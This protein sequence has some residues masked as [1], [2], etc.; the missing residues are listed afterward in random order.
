MRLHHDQYAPADRPLLIPPG[1]MELE[2][3]FVD[4]GYMRRG[5]TAALGQGHDSALPQKRFVKF[6]TRRFRGNARELP[7]PKNKR[8]QRPVRRMSA[9]APLGWS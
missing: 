2:D 4:Q 1:T 9:R 8:D 7:K 6:C 5:I 3:L